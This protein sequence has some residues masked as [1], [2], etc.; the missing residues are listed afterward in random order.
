MSKQFFAVLFTLGLLSAAPAG[1]AS[2]S[3]QDLLQL[4]EQWRVV[5]NACRAISI[6]GVSAA[7]KKDSYYLA[8]V[9]RDL[10]NKIADYLFTVH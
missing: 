8:V 10:R 6:S 7:S 2:G 5:V 4:F 9:A 3:Y 1:H